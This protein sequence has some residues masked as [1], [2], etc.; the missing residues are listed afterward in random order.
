MSID[1]QIDRGEASLAEMNSA[2]KDLQ[3][4]RDR[5]EAQ[6]MQ[7]RRKREREQDGRRN[8]NDWT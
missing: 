7:L 6:V 2:I 3:R 8:A 1:Q 4:M 5:K